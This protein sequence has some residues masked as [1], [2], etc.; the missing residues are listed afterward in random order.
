M[1]RRDFSKVVRPLLPLLI[2]LLFATAASAYQNPVIFA[3]YSDPDVV[4]SGSDYYLVASSFQMVPGLP[5]LHSRDLV[6]WE[7]VAYA[8]QQLP[9]PDFDHAQHGN[10]L[11]APSIREHG[12][13]FWIY[14]GDPDRGIYVTKARDPRGPW[15]PLSLVKEAKGWIDPCPLWDDDGSMYLVHAWAKSRAG[16]NS[17]L[18]VNRM[19]ADGRRVVDDGRVV[20]DGR[21]HHPTLEGP[22]FYKRNGWYY[23]FAPAGGVKTGDQVVLRSK[24]V[25][26]PYE[27]KVV[28]EQGSTAINGPHQGGWVDA[29]DGTNWFVHFQDRGAWGRV[30]LLE[31]MKWVNEWPEIGADGKPVAEHE[32]PRGKSPDA[33]QPRNLA[34]PHLPLDWQWQANP[35][36]NWA[37]YHDGNIRLA[38]VPNDGNLWSATNLLLRKFVGPSFSATVRV[39]ASRLRTGER[40]GLV[41]MGEDYSALVVERTASG[42]AVRRVLNRNAAKSNAEQTLGTIEVNAPVF[43]RVDVS[44]QAVCRF[45]YSRDGHSY[46]PLGGAFVATPGRWVGAKVGLFAS[47]SHGG[48]ADFAS[49]E[50]QPLTATDDVTLVVAQDGSGDYTTIQAAVDALPHD[51]TTWRTVLIR[52]GVYREKVL[53]TTSRVALV[54]ENRDKTRIEFAELR[55]NW[56]ASHPDDWGSAVINIDTTDVIIAN[57]TVHNDY[58]AATGD[59]D[60][61][62]AIR[63]MDNA[64]RIA[65]LHANVIADGGDTLSLWNAE[66]GLSYYADSYFEG[67]VDYVCPRGWAYVTNSRFFGHN[68]TA[69]IWHDGSKNKSQKFVIRHSSFDGVPNFALGR[70]HRDGQ[71]YLIEDRFSASMADKPIYPS[72]APDP[73]QW[74]ERY[75][76]ASD[77]RTR[78]DYAWFADNLR[79]AEGSPREEDVTA[80]WA[81]DGQW[82]PASLP[83]VL[84]FAAIPQPENGWRW[85]DPAGVTLRWTRARNAHAQRVYFGETNPPQL[86]GEQSRSSYETGPLEPG[87]TYY[88]RIDDG[89]VWSF[90]TDPRTLRI[91]LAGDST[92]TEKSGYGRGLKSYIANDTAFLNAARGGRSSKSYAA[93]G[94]WKELLRHKPTYILIQFGHN[95][96][97]GK[98]LDRETDLPTF[99]ANMA[100]YVDE[101]RAAGATPILITPLTR[102]FFG[103]DSRIHSDLTAYADQTR[104]VASEKHVPLIDLHAKSIE[105]LDRLGPSV[106]I[107]MSPLKTDGTIDKTHLNDAGS[108]LIGALMADELRHAIPELAPHIR[109]VASLPIPTPLWSVRM[110][111]SVMKRTPN[112]LLLDVPG[113]TPKW[114]YT[115]GL[116]LLAIQQLA[117]KTG[118]ERY[119]AYV[120]A[121]YDHMIDG[122]GAIKAYTLEEYSLDRINAGKELFALYEKTH[123]EKY[124]KAIEL[125]RE[126]LRRQ[127]RNPDRGFWHKKRYPRQMWLDG[128]YMAAPFLAQYAKTFNDPKAFDDIVP[129]FVLM[130]QHA[131]DE[132]TGL[133]VH[134]Y[135][136]ARE[137]KWADPKTGKSPAFWGRAMGWYAMGLVDSLD[138]IPVD[139]PRRHELIDILNRF[140]EAIVKVQ[141]PK[142]GVWWQVVDQPGRERNYLESSASTMFAYVLLKASRL[143]YLDPRYAAIGRRAYDGVV[144]QF[145]TVDESGLA[146]INQAVAV[147]GLGGD[148]NA[149]GRY[150]DG[151]YDYYVSEKTRSNDP[152][153]VGPFILASLEIERR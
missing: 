29:P 44:P 26:G 30:V 69:S 99:R 135:D 73:R 76:Y 97:A 16:F 66:S 114:D 11:W 75:Y 143:G 3:D 86:R 74:G 104:S 40:A 96:V 107:A 43:F 8:A 52:N 148:P 134:G 123:D 61:Q 91:A 70:N 150:R 53:L 89:A 56:R 79:S 110:A 130:E 146:N 45:G 24:N 23:I 92:M 122:S 80:A 106:G 36:P 132:K 78:G 4:R 14:V 49:F 2:A 5:I 46:E 111:D 6:H 105:L 149:E 31:P 47:G 1:T 58:G 95:D 137:Q 63:S 136:D 84:P 127:P 128:L 142:T 102:R 129:Q 50:M 15:E 18:S 112:P 119:A 72:P 55:R 145:I 101:A 20:F 144:K 109:P 93:E 141:D 25:Y 103:A 33:S 153:A 42:L 65:I 34:T 7:L 68:T 62:F 9:S 87:K 139:H 48:H 71:F 51:G 35:E 98:G 81:F 13:W 120:R 133:L 59:H 147:V 113:V 64:N 124:R 57:L 115:Q 22:K 54:G 108:A 77:H 94:H 125:L 126:Q 28:L 10:G 118:D 83:A 82:D 152:K 12:G 90:R 32:S 37:S 100:R 117:Q 38:T 131:R 138:Y 19:S 67:Y 151:T 41:V 116:V 17:V 140:A 39:D 85:V 88:W 27:D 21:E 60:H 121:Y